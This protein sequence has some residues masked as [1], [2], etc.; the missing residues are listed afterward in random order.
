MPAINIPAIGAAALV[1][2]SNARQSVPALSPSTSQTMRIARVLCILAL[3]Y[4]HTPPYARGAPADLISADGLYWIW[5]ELAGR[6]SVALLSIFS[7]LLVVRLGQSKTW[8]VNLRKKV[9]TLII[10]LLLWNLIALAKNF[11]E[12]GGHELPALSD[13]PHLLLA[14]DGNP[15]LTPTYFLRDVFVFNLLIVPLMFGARHATMVTGLLLLGNAVFGIDGKLFLNN[16]IPLFF[17]LGL[18]V[19]IGAMSADRLPMRAV[20]GQGQGTIAV[21][22]AISLMLA[23]A[24]GSY[25]LAGAGSAWEYLQHLSDVVGRLGGA[26]LFWTIAD[27]VSGSRAASRVGA[28]EPVIFLSSART[29]SALELPGSRRRLRT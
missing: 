16:A 20:R 26:L 23:G 13:M 15:A 22:V 14:L 10:P 18:L 12:S 24:S 29:R 7:G 8:S 2:K 19:G 6:T 5:R 27:R 3:V 11:A 17:F 9:R 21:S 1:E 28:F 4:V 25:L